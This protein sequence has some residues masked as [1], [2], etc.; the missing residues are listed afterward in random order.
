MAETLEERIAKAKAAGYTQ[1][2]INESLRKHGVNLS[3][4]VSS[5]PQVSPITSNPSA[6]SSGLSQNQIVPSDSGIRQR[7]YLDTL[8][9]MSPWISAGIGGL[10]G[11]GSSLT[12]LGSGAASLLGSGSMAI[13]DA[14]MNKFLYNKQ[15]YPISSRLGITEENK[16]P[17]G[18]SILDTGASIAEN[19][20]V[21][22]VLGRA[23]G[24]P[25]KGIPKTGNA[26]HNI[27][28]EA[29]TKS[30]GYVQPII[31]K[32]RD[33]A[34]D[35]F[36][37]VPTG[38]LGKGAITGDLA[39]YDPTFVQMLEA[40]TGHKHPIIGLPEDIFAKKNKTEA[41]NKSLSKIVDTA[42][43]QVQTL[44]GQK[45]PITLTGKPNTRTL[46]DLAT[47]M[48]NK[49]QVNYENLTNEIDD[50]IQSLKPFKDQINDI[51]A[52]LA[53]APKG[54]PEAKL[55]K[56]Q[57]TG[58]QKDPT[59]SA[60]STKMDALAE[61]RSNF[62]FPGE[63]GYSVED[64]LM[65]DYKTGRTTIDPVTGRNMVYAKSVSDVLLD[66]P[67]KLQRFFN[68]GEIQIGKT[69]ITSAS[70]RKEAAGYQFGRMLNEAY[71]AATDR[72]DMQKLQ[73]I[74]NDYKV[75][76][77][78]RKVYSANNRAD[79]DQLFKTLSYITP[80]MTP[81]ASKYLAIRLGLG[82][83]TLGSGLVTGMI[84]GSAPA[85]MLGAGAIVGGSIGLHQLGKMMTNPDT[86]RLMIAAA[87]GGPLNMSTA[88]AGRII[89]RALRGELITMDYKNEQGQPIQIK[90]K[91]DSMGKFVAEG[92]K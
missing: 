74:W 33:K 68:T 12:G 56:A 13:S 77:M 30:S 25:L 62:I 48:R 71:D 86:A 2:Q 20:A 22:E 17:T 63:K 92:Q 14:I 47:T 11:I 37:I 15:N 3:S 83:A 59:Y 70:P 38:K 91:I 6:T 89:G 90:G 80:E 82:A 58:L 69:K 51:E 50:T 67:E 45:I 10:A 57:L 21:N 81:G 31:A 61:A 64:F 65:K 36:G 18:N 5:A 75:S 1:D 60:L 28:A 53:V 52:K 55:L 73:N 72:L 35:A 39:A 79:Y 46:D 76:D 44:I 88:T 23:I 19:T 34:M 42:E 29:D 54:T 9:D 49:S 8:R 66:D 78:G 84:T 41:L 26:V 43:G 32:I 16:G 40:D 4:P 87:K 24:F 7:G 85:G 27:L